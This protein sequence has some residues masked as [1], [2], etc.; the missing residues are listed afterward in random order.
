MSNVATKDGG[1]AFQRLDGALPFFPPAPADKILKWQPILEEL[2]QYTLKVSG[3]KEGQY[4]ILVDGRKIAEHSA[5]Q[6]ADGVNLAAGALA[7]GPIAEHVKA[8]WTAVAAKNS[9]FHDKIFR[10]IT[11]SNSNVPDWLEIPQAEVDARRK[12]AFESRMAKMPELD[13]A[14]RK[15]LEMKP[16][17]FEVVPKK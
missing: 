15:A 14:V 16:H 8:V 6:L 17:Q 4:E 11:L 2:N 1:V 5:S 7:G 12:A 13:A 9:F 10:G 3:L